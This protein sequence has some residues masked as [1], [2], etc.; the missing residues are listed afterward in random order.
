MNAFRNAV[1][2]LNMKSLSLPL[3]GVLLFLSSASGQNLVTNG[4]FETGTLAGWTTTM[5]GANTGYVANDGSTFTSCGG[6]Y[7]SWVSPV[8]VIAGTYSVLYDH[9][10]GGTASLVSD[11]LVLPEACSSLKYSMDITYESLAPL[12]DMSQN[13][14]VS[15]LDATMAPIAT[16]YSLTGSGSSGATA[17]VPAS[18]TCLFLDTSTGSGSG[19]WGGGQT[20]HLAIETI[21]Q[22][23]CLP[24]Q[25]DNIS[26]VC[27]DPFTAMDIELTDPCYCENPENILLPGGPYLF[28]D[29]LHV[30][31]TAGLTI[32]LAAND[33]NFVDATNTAIPVGTVFAEVTPGEYEL[34]FFTASGV[35]ADIEVSSGFGSIP[36]TA[37]G[38]IFENC[39]SATLACNDNV[40]ISLDYSCEAEL[41]PNLILSGNGIGCPAQVRIKTENDVV[42]DASTGS[43][44]NIVYPVI[45]SEYIGKRWKAEIFVMDATGNI[46]DD[47]WGYF[48]V[49]DK[50]APQITCLE[51][52]TVSCKDDLE[53]MTTSVSDFSLC[54]TGTD[55]DLT[56]VALTTLVFDVSAGSY[57]A[58]EIINSISVG[59]PVAATAS[60]AKF[61]IDGVDISIPTTGTFPNLEYDF[62]VIE[63]TLASYIPTMTITLPDA[64]LPAGGICM[65]TQATSFAAINVADN[66]SNSEIL[67][68]RD[69]LD[70]NDCGPSGITATRLIEY[71]ARDAGGLV[72]VPCSFTVSYEKVLLDDVDFPADYTGQCS[73]G[74]TPGT[75]VTGVPTVGGC[76][77]SL[78]E[79]LCKFNISYTDDRTDSS[80]S[81]YTILRKWVVLDWCAGQHRQSYQTIEISDT[82]PPVEMGCPEDDIIV[83]A[84]SG[85]SGS[86]TFK[87]LDSLNQFGLVFVP[88]DCST[89]SYQGEF[90]T[91]DERDVNEVDQDYNPMGNLGNSM[92]SATL[93][94]GQNSIKYVATDACGNSTQCTF[95]VIVRDNQAPI[96]VCDQYTAVS[97]DDSGWGRLYGR[98][99]DDGSY[100][101]CGGEVSF[102][103]RRNDAPCASLSDYVGDDTV[104]GDFVQFCCS[105]AGDT[106][107]TILK[108][109]D[110]GG[111][112]NTC[113]VNVV[114]QDK[115]GNFS[116]GCPTPLVVETP[117]LGSLNDIKGLF[118]SPSPSNSCGGV[119]T[120]ISEDSDDGLDVCGTG[121]I[122]RTWTAVYGQDTTSQT[123]VQSINVTASGT[124][125]RNSFNPPA[126]NPVANCGNYTEDNGDGPSLKP[127]SNFCGDVGFTFEDS[128][129]FSVEG[130][131]VKVIRT[132][133][134]IDFCN[135]DIATGEGS[136]TWTQ[137]IKVSDDQG[138]EITG[139]PDDITVVASG[140]DCEALVNVPMPSATDLC[141]DRELPA[142]SFE[143][144]LSG[145]AFDSGIGNTASDTLGVGTYTL[146]WVATGLCGVASDADSCSFNIVVEDNSTPT[147]Y[148]RSTVNTVISSADPGTLPTVDIWASD[149][150]L[151][152]VDDCDDNLSVSF[153]GTDLNDTQRVYGCHQLGFH[154]VEIYFTDSSGNQDFCVASVHIQANGNICDTIGARA[155]RIEGDVYTENLE[156]IE[157]V[158]IGLQEMTT[159]QMNIANTDSQGHFAFENIDSGDDYQ[160]LPTSA[161]DYLNGVSTLDLIMIQRHILGLEQ[162]DSP[163]KLIAADINGS[164]NIN[165]LDLI[166]LRKL[167]LG[168]YTELP[169][170]DSWN[171][172]DGAQVFVD[173]SAPWP[174]TKKIELNQP[175]QDMMENDFI[176]VKIG[177]V[178]SSAEIN[179]AAGQLSE[180]STKVRI[181]NEVHAVK[182]GQEYLIPIYF[183]QDVT[184]YGLQ[185]DLE[186]RN[187]LKVVNI[188]SGKLDVSTG[189]VLLKEAQLTVSYDKEF[190]FDIK[191]Q[192]ALFYVTVLTSSHLEGKVFDFK[193]EGLQNELYGDNYEVMG[194]SLGDNIPSFVTELKQNVPNPFD[195][196]TTI[197]FILPSATNVTLNVLN[198]NG[199]IIKSIKGYYESGRHEITLSSADLN[200]KGVYYY[201]LDT[202]IYSATKKMIHME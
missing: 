41:I 142:S 22:D 94:V 160:L 192:E 36:F 70:S 149:F 44:F 81:D 157:N 21:T 79:N 140:D 102:E 129:F 96:P 39:C 175:S 63:G 181:Q 10:V 13:I 57:N 11:A 59:T 35:S 155:I 109:I 14:T 179:S 131:C 60:G 143:W 108:V 136:W 100:D 103:V 174:F 176:A 190:L 111:L 86:Y 188:E 53:A 200:A 52:I 197:E 29:Y 107:E 5:T 187:D 38:C 19:A 178:N 90:L 62:T 147:P 99:L 127:G 137:T 23:G 8:P 135:Y 55:T 87:P 28:H 202:E 165:G 118:G 80:C 134:A 9:T 51:D 158:E 168:I 184:V 67:I 26:L 69:E 88:T 92:F 193:N 16:F 40:Q 91:A 25:I 27:Q 162:L 166:E 85:C 82:E 150:D 123:C 117:C 164:E 148:C 163:Y 18:N 153:S 201:Q 48:T 84:T 73:D 125:T 104:F 130:Y 159:T 50:L 3:L 47:C 128:P 112:Y 144:T 189:N 17:Q 180:R 119:P 33:G 1:N 12:S 113:T 68:G 110:E 151:G 43:G 146:A 156:M 177:D 4:D 98:S 71:I 24:H 56:D 185:L 132:W 78:T 152:S 186:F 115:H 72:S 194:V 42:V 171:F 6:A 141:F 46:V 120:F 15:V 122:S 198:L 66:C 77:L 93:P 161:D 116:L 169:Q 95:E 61:T 114:V 75:D 7:G 121:T 191:S 2:K 172:V 83:D 138:P 133:T 105:E 139:C 64:D 195:G 20:V 97:L 32:S 126:A 182:E 145:S 30:S 89:I 101:Q 54:T 199:K 65:T 31:T 37:G 170:N 58:W 173:P 106:V 183:D 76:D 49:E 154:T 167:I 34:E 124:L 74:E 45:G 196:S